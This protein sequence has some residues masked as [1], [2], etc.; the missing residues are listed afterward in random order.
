[1]KISKYLIASF[2]ILAMTV[3]AASA[4]VIGTTD[5][6]V[7]AIAEPALDSI[8]MG[9]KTGNYAEYS[10]DFDDTLKEAVPE[11]QFVKVK[12]QIDGTLGS[13]E[14]KTYLG[15]LQKGPTTVILWKGK[16]S[17]SKDDQL[18]KL[19]MSKRGNKDLVTGLW[20]Q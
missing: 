8:L 19:I 4:E 13:C 5:K 7:R 14:S 17:K 1:M 6:E 10:K 11:D 20:F 12:D 16:F 3:C 15:Y 2:I 9:L 18:I